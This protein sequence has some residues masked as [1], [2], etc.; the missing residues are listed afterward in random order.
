[1]EYMGNLGARDTHT[2]RLTEYLKELGFLAIVDKRA[3]N[4]WPRR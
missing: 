3:W 2:E 1:M 4:A